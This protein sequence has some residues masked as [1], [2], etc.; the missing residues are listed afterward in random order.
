VKSVWWLPNALLA[1]HDPRKK[2]WLSSHEEER[3]KD[4]KCV[5]FSFKTQKKC[6]VPIQNTK[7]VLGAHLMFFLRGWTHEE[8]CQVDTQCSLLEG[9][10]KKKNTK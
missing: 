1:K 7:E 8:K 5:G 4:K 6:W 3:K 9:R 10:S 2:P